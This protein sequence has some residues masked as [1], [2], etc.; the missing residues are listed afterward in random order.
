MAFGN[1]MQSDTRFKRYP[2][3]RV[4]VEDLK[5]GAWND[6]E[7]NLATRYGKLKRIRLVGLIIR[8][9]DVADP[10]AGEDS[11]L[12]DTVQGN[13]RVS[14]LVDDGTGQIWATMWGVDPNS[15]PDLVTGCLVD[16][17]GKV[18][19]YQNN[20]QL[21][22]ELIHELAD[23]NYE[24]YHLLEVLKKRKLEPSF[25]VEKVEENRF[26][27]YQ[28][29]DK[30]AFEAKMP[31]PTSFADTPQP[32]TGGS[33]PKTTQ[34]GAAPNVAFSD[35]LSTLTESPT[36]TTAQNPEF[37]SLDLKDQIIQFI[38]TNDQ[39]DGVALTVIADRFG[40]SKEELKGILD[41]LCQDIQLYK[42]QPGHYASY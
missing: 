19:I 23:P 29:D 26:D 3:V 9:K 40:T 21:T 41:G 6:E 33:T 18:R 13:G 20:P 32:N 38:Q 30:A 35:S 11:F 16:M 2:S 12:E 17:V 10:Q 34:Q 4:L 24:A 36:P 22:L 28:F 25:T 39:G 15:Y 1:T 31:E 7:K 42:S 27:G 5:A 14:F 37:D 8:R